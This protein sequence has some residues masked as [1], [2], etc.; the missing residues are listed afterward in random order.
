MS[1]YSHQFL[2]AVTVENDE[3]DPHKVT[4][5]ELLEALY[6]R[7]KDIHGPGGDGIEAFGHADTAEI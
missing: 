3:A 7:T 1:H 6:R 2:I 5:E 4:E